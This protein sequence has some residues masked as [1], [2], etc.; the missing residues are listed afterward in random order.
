MRLRAG[1]ALALAMLAAGCIG[2]EGARVRSEG[3]A[4]SVLALVGGRVQTEPGA[5]A[6][7][8]GVVVVERGVIAAV[9]P[10]GEVS[11]PSGALVLDCAGATVSAGFWN[12]HVHFTQPVWSGA[13]SAPAD[14]LAA[15]LRAMLTSYGIVGVLDTGSYPSDTLALRQRIESGEVPGPA[16]M[17]AGGGFAPAG[18]SPYYL[19]P[20]RLPELAR[21]QDA[22]PM[23]STMIALGT[24]AV[25]LFT[26]SYAER[27]RI[28]IMPVE[29]VR[30]AVDAAH[31]RGKPVVAHPSN[32]AG[33]RAA[34]DGGVDILAH[35][36]PSEID[37]P[38]DRSLPGRMRERGM[39]LIPTLKLW[40]YELGKLG[41][42]PEIIQRVLGAGEA[43]VRA[44]AD[45]GGHILFGTDVGYM[46]DYDPTDEYVYLQRAGLSYAQILAT[47]TTT[48]AQR[49]GL[50]ARNG[51]LAAGFDADIAVVEGE[52]ERDIRALAR[53]RYTLRSG[54][55]IFEGVRR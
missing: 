41:L 13:A 39:A 16:I 10:R 21:A 43:Q 5:A 22:D 1:I 31:R 24:D 55:V 23:V 52:P 4:Q 33:A 20:T 40:P 38:W 11:V 46:T 2:D 34:V 28:V 51:R 26:G 45:L 53:V 19:L 15:A 27:N 3:P 54:R 9:G 32:S 50:A 35:T 17:T 14:R 47:L 44:F 36:F 18:G 49:F 29:I 42:P 6:I 30:A 7:P 8:N 48:P 37:G 25:K 12:S